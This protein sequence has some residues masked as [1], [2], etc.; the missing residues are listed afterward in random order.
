MRLR[1]SME[2]SMSATGDGVCHPFLRGKPRP[3][4]HGSKLH[5]GPHNRR[6]SENQNKKRVPQ[7][8]MFTNNSHHLA[9]MEFNKHTSQKLQGTAGESTRTI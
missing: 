8:D 1:S 5:A 4:T 9:E 6:T 2:M 7:K 3:L